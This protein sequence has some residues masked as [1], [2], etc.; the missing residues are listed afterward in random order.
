MK[1]IMENWK[2][3]I[4]EQAS[5]DDIKRAR[6]EEEKANFD[7]FMQE[8]CKYDYLIYMALDH[9]KF[10]ITMLKIALSKAGASADFLRALIKYIES[11]TGGSAEELSS[12]RT[13]RLA[14]SFV[15]GMLM[16]ACIEYK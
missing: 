5:E 7:Q 13:G 6:K 8:L 10:T 9:P 4:N 3:F 16:S 15:K 12:T 2:A 14:R 1:L 11:I